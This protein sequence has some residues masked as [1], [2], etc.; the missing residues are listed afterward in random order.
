M[1]DNEKE[2]TWKMLQSFYSVIQG[3]PFTPTVDNAGTICIKLF[4]KLDK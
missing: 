3:G 2:N 1:P 4:Y